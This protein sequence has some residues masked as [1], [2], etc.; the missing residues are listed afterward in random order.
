MRTVK[1]AG[2]AGKLVKRLVALFSI[3][4][5]SLYM[6]PQ[7]SSLPEGEQV[8]SGSA[9]FERPDSSTLNINTSSDRLIVNYNSF[10]IAQPEAVNFYQPSSSSVALNRVVGLSPSEIFGILS[11]TGK[12]Y[13]INPNGILFGASSQVDVAG[14]IAST[15]DIS[16]ENFLGGNYT[17]AKNADKVGASVINRGYLKGD[18]VALLGSA[19]R[20][21][22][23]I[24]TTLGSTVLASGEKVTLG[25]DTAGMISVVI[26]EAVKEKISDVTDGIKNTGKIIADGGRVILTAKALD[27]VFDYAV[28]N[29]GVIQAN[30]MDAKTGKV[31]L[32]A[33]QRVNVAGE[34]NAI[35][36]TVTVDSEGADYSG[37]INSAKA[38]LNANDGDSFLSGSHTTDFTVNDNLH[39]FVVGNF[40]V[41]G[42]L[43]IRADHNNDGS[44]V[45]EQAANT[46]MSAT[47]NIY[48]EGA[49]VYIADAFFGGLAS[50]TFEALAK[51]GEVKVGHY[52]DH[53]NGTYTHT[54]YPAAATDVGDGRIISSVGGLQTLDTD[55]STPGIQPVY[56]SNSGYIDQARPTIVPSDGGNKFFVQGGTTARKWGWLEFA[57]SPYA[58]LLADA[59][60][61]SGVL[62]AVSSGNTARAVIG[63]YQSLG[64]W[65]GSHTWNNQPTI[66]AQPFAIGTIAKN[67]D[68]IVCE[69]A[70]PL[71]RDLIPGDYLFTAFVQRYDGID[72]QIGFWDHNASNNRDKP[73]LAITYY[74]LGSGNIVLNSGTNSGTGTNITLGRLITKGNVEANAVR[75][76]IIDNNAEKLNV[77]EANNLI[78]SALN[79]IGS[80]DALETKVSTIAAQN[81]GSGNIKIDNTGN[82]SIANLGGINGVSNSAPGGSVN[83]SAAS[84]LTVGA[85]ISATGNIVLTASSGSILQNADI[86]ITQA[87]PVLPTP[88]I[89]RDSASHP[90]DIWRA[91]VSNDN[92]VDISWGLNAP[93][94]TRYS[95]TATSSGAYTQSGAGTDITTNGGDVTINAGENVTLT[96]I[97]AGAGAVSITTPGSIIDGDGFNVPTDYDIKARAITL[98][99]GTTTNL[100]YG[101]LSTPVASYLDIG[102]PGSGFSYSWTS[103]TQGTATP[104]L[105]SA[106]FT[107]GGNWVFSNTSSALADADD[108]YFNVA[109]VGGGSAAPYG[110]F[111]ID[112]TAPVITARYPSANLYGW[113]KDDVTVNFSATDNLSGF[114]PSGSLTATNYNSQTTSGEGAPITVTSALISDRAGNPATLVNVGLNI[115]KTAPTITYLPAAG[116]YTSDITVAFSATDALSGVDG[117]SWNPSN[118]QSTAGDGTYIFSVSVADLAGN[119][120]GLETGAF[121]VSLPV[122]ITTV[123]VP[124]YLTE[125]WRWPVQEIIGTDSGTRVYAM[126]P[127]VR[128]IP[129]YFYRPVVTTDAAAFDKFSLTADMY[130]FIEQNIRGRGEGFFPWLEEE[131]KKKR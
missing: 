50:N 122:P 67:N 96:L 49:D 13:L 82:L 51:T 110:A 71:Q 99:A 74:T 37:S 20:N 63:I 83:I 19:V 102:Y 68:P 24:V 100:D 4:V 62:T 26:D 5:F 16:N 103:T 39:V 43:T 46:K 22:G 86:T 15:L 88:Y 79:G 113:Y 41:T 84:D 57:L 1:L 58:S 114:D 76:A 33:N 70:D 98:T 45:F 6:I 18:K 90:T 93:G 30:T 29:E 28:N 52:K 72:S 10:S 17:F 2:R 59:F 66:S 108:W 36:G 125:R 120:A 119:L 75:G 104:T 91:G 34:I 126:D 64:D 61:E 55:P 130:E 89:I 116:T 129:V 85:P 131:F 21:E 27:N 92:T 101:Q 117:T 44:G 38:I 32:V 80:G 40:N 94:G 35:G 9:T 60:I 56:A 8:V 3:A 112:T 12:I 54:S 14:L 95:F 123:L 124:D 87:A 97:D 47:G 7:V 31:E 78:L 106:T 111:Y 65:K 11:A 73:S 128:P 107:T 121:I 109:V 69:A 118:S 105:Y 115:D 127:Q 48:I 25:L 42:N 23:T 77:L 81:T 53:I